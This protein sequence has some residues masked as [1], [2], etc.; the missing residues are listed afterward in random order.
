MK[1]LKKFKVPIVLKTK[2]PKEKGVFILPHYSYSTFN[3]FSNNPYM[4]KVNAINGDYLE[5][6]TSAASMLGTACHKALQTYLGGNPDIPTPANDGEAIKLGHDI[7]LAYIDS[8]FGNLV[9]FTSTI[10]TM[11]VLKEKYAYSYFGYIKEFGVI[12][13]LKEILLVE[14]MLK[15]YVEVDG[16]LLAVPLKGSADLVYRDTKGRIIIVD[17]KFTGKYSEPEEID[18]A[19]L[20]QAAFMYFLVYAELGEAPHSIEFRE[21]KTVPNKDKSPQTKPFTIV[22]KEAEMIFSLFYRMYEDITDALLGKQVYVPNF[23]ARY[24]K[25][26]AIMAYIHRLDIDEERANKFKEEQVDNITDFLKKRIERD[27]SMKKYME[28][29]TTKFV[30]ASTLNYKEMKIEERIKMKLAEHGLGL[31]FDSMIKGGSV[32][33]YRYE[34]SI[35]LKMSKIEA[36]AKDIEQVV[37]VSGIRVLAPIADSG[38]VGFEVPNQTRTFPKCVPEPQGF[39]IAIGQDIMGDPYRFDIREAPHM[40]VAGSSGS[41]KSVFLHSVISQLLKLKNVELYLCD[42]KQVELS[43]YDEVVTEYRDSHEDI[44]TLLESLVKEME[45][46]YSKMKEAKVRNISEIDSMPYKFVVIDEYAD[47][48]LKGGVENTIQLLAQKGRA[49]GIHLIIATQRAS[50]KIINGDILVNF[51]TKV[52]FRVSKEVDSRVML[53]E[54]GAE[55]LLGKGDMLFSTSSGI[56]RLQGY[57]V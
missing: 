51:P 14:K 52:V 36:Y 32:T 44:S 26:V 48:T 29:V 18:G 34:P 45:V 24:D 25:E 35:G 30:S 12:K 15:H 43:H 10:P 40:L 27:G 23:T 8:I 50:T 9:E 3:K 57:V 49:C 2:V 19:K 21:F 41:G 22:Y 28:S 47:L 16:K 42:P 1:K 38:L 11:Q 56:T 5:T 17:H 13:K 55:K 39:N 33:L 54:S 31:Q 46:R 7:G 6:T 53:N 4:F 37:E 20:I